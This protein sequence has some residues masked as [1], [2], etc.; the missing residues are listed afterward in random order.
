MV[1]S[2]RIRAYK[3]SNTAGISHLIIRY[4][5]Y[6]SFSAKSMLAKNGANMKVLIVLVT[7]MAVSACTNSRLFPKTYS[8]ELA[9]KCQTDP[10][11]AYCLQ[12]PAAIKN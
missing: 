3:L 1:G 5:R 6:T 11:G 10:Y 4:K 12:P 8:P 2:I 9:Y 7:V